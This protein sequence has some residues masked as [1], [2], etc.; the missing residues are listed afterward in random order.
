MVGIPSRETDQILVQVRDNTA[1]LEGC[2]GPHD[3]SIALDR[4]T[5][6]PISNPTPIQSFACKWQCSKCGGYVDGINKIWYNRGLNH[7]KKS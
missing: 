3:F 4:H 6:Q 7:S 1:K 2:P 5:K